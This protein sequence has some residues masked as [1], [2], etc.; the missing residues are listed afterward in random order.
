MAGMFGNRRRVPG[1]YTNPYSSR[2]PRWIEKFPS[3]PS[4]AQVPGS[5]TPVFPDCALG[6]SLRFTPDSVWLDL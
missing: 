2:D 5:L 3:K 6:Q 1:T 4:D